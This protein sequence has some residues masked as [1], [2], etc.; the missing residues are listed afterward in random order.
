M[1]ISEDSW[2]HLEVLRRARIAGLQLYWDESLGSFRLV[3]NT[4]GPGNQWMIPLLRREVEPL[5]L[6]LHWE[7][8]ELQKGKRPC[9]VCHAYDWCEI[10]HPRNTVSP[11]GGM[12]VDTH[13]PC[14]QCSCPYRWQHVTWSYCINCGET[15][16]SPP[17]TWTRYV[18]GTCDCLATQ[19]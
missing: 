1:N 17:P 13:E 12:L 7:H 16:G 18:C 6:R 2:D 4:V 11:G 3:K 15:R 9:P 19:A 8:N 14:G 10:S 5:K